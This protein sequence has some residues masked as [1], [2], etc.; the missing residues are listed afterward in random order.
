MF[1]IRQLFFALSR[2]QIFITDDVACIQLKVF[3]FT[4]YR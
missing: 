3:R 1:I 4:P 2:S